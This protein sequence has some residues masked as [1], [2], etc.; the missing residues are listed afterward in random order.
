M[1]LVVGD[2]VKLSLGDLVAADVR[3]VDGSILLDQ[4]MLT[5][6]SLPVEAGAGRDTFSGALVKRGEATAKVT[7]TAQE[8]SSGRPPSW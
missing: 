1:E 4:S 3:I 8:P 2:L 5:G 7:A 6:E